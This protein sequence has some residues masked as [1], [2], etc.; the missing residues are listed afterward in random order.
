MHYYAIVGG[1]SPGFPPTLNG[2]DY[3][4]VDLADLYGVT[5]FG[6]VSR[7]ST[8]FRHYGAKPQFRNFLIWELKFAEKTFLTGRTMTQFKWEKQDKLLL[9]FLESKA[10]ESMRKF[11]KDELD[12]VWVGIDPKVIRDTDYSKSPRN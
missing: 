1:N 9:E 4:K 5:E 2:D 6:D 11:C 3:Y 12:G 10:A 7:I 8:V